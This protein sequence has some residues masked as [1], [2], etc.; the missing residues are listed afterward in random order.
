MNSA[1]ALQKMKDAQLNT[2]EKL[3]KANES[4][5]AKSLF[6]I[7]GNSRHKDELGASFGEKV[8]VFTNPFAPLADNAKIAVKPFENPFA[9]SKPIGNDSAVFQNPFKSGSLFDLGSNVS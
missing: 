9:T 6:D 1:D 5:I 3:K 7:K 8:P 2:K 4:P